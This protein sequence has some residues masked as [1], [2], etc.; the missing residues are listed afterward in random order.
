MVRLVIDNRRVEV[1]QGATILTAA[2]KLG[3]EI[4]TLCY[5]EGLAPSTSC[6][7]CVVKDL[8]RGRLVPACAAKAEEGMRIESESE[9]VHQARRAA[10]ELLLSDHPG[11]CT[12]PCQSICP[13]HMNIPQMIRQIADGQ[14]RSAIETVKRDIALP[15]VL[16]RICPGPCEKGCR[17]GAKDGPVPIC[18]L[19][20]YAAD[21]DLAG[22]ESFLPVCRPSRNKGIAIVGSGPAGLAAAYYLLQEGYH[23]EVFDEHEKPGGNLRYAVPE[24]KLP[25][26]VLDAEI[27]QISKLGAK[28]RPGTKIGADNSPSLA[29]L[30]KEFEA[31]LLAVGKIN[32]NEI[33]GMGLAV[34]KNGIKANNQTYATELAGVFAAGNAIRPG[35]LAVRAAADGKNAAFCIDQYLTGQEV[36][37]P[38]GTF[39]TH[40]GKLQEGEIDRFMA[41]ASNAPPVS[42]PGALQEGLTKDEAQI[43]SRR[44]LHCDCRKALNCRLRHYAGIYRADPTRYQ[45][46]RRLFEQYNANPDII[47]EPGKCIDCGRCIHIAATAGEKLGLTFVGRGFDVRV[48]TPFEKTI[49]E[50]LKQVAAQCAQACPTGALTLKKKPEATI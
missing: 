18:L 12:A 47:Y 14:M 33:A 19:K 10:L 22:P 44:C 34:T 3:I 16:G 23:C 8:G 5:F 35:R 26:E 4:P 6:M 50:G 46:T 21:V 48:A 2:K 24:D 37:G 7:V 9:E 25:R 41:Q 1:E 31:V 15:G 38:A 40:I 36:T 17:R 27:N 49:A 30:Q 13:A 28:F 45:G 39:S 43:Q 29:D 11:D 32:P 20:R 42:R